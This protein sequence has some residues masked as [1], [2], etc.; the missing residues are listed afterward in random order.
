MMDIGGKHMGPVYQMLNTCQ[1]YGLLGAITDAVWNG[2][3]MSL[4]QWKA[5]V[6]NIVWDREYARWKS[7]IPMYSKLEL[8][9]LAT[10]DVQK[11][12]HWPW[13]THAVGGQVRKCR[14]LMRLMIGEHGLQENRSRLTRGA[15][16]ETTTCQLCTMFES[17]TVYHML[18]VCPSLQV[19]RDTMWGHVRTAAPQALVVQMDNMLPKDR[20]VFIMSCFNS[21]YIREWQPTYSAILD[22][23]AAMYGQRSSLYDSLVLNRV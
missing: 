3:N 11:I 16:R 14:L 21:C 8:F 22:F 13:W 17:E 7:T 5:N 12:C 23:V 19:V 18:F 6:R 20:T 9:R 15:G 2:A 10:A 1:R 4:K